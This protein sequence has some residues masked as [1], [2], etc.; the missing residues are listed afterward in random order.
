MFSHRSV[1]DVVVGLAHPAGG[2][3]RLDLQDGANE[4]IGL[5]GLEGDVGV[6]MHAEDLGL[7]VLRELL[8]VLAVLVDGLVHR[9]RSRCLK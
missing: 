4:R 9:G 6:L 5:L 3:T 2:G 1:G 8:D 7:I